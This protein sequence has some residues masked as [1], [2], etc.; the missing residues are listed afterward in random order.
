MLLIQVIKP[1]PPP[2][3]PNPTILLIITQITQPQR[4]EPTNSTSKPYITG[5]LVQEPL[6]LV[7]DSFT[8]NKVHKSI[9]RL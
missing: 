6:A 7:T 9:T 8:D 3:P 2:H 4:I 5:A 1:T